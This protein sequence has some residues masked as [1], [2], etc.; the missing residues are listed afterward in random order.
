MSVAQRPA[1]VD[2]APDHFVLGARL[3]YGC[4]LISWPDMNMAALNVHSHRISLFFQVSCILQRM[5]ET[6]FLSVLDAEWL[7][8]LS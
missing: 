5:K 6:N 8:N 4:C 1:C 3:Y 2:R 7:G